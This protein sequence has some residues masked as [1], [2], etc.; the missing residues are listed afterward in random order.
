MRQPIV[1]WTKS[2]IHEMSLRRRCH[3]QSDCEYKPE[4][5]Q[6]WARHPHSASPEIAFH[7]KK[8]PA[9]RNNSPRTPQAYLSGRPSIHQPDSD[10]QRVKE[11]GGHDETDT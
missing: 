6:S 11:A 2:R 5:N 10:A 3:S 8:P 4:C 1:E 7:R 9:D